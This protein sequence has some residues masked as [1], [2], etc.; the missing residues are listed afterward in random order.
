MR[1]R[2]EGVPP[3]SR[4]GVRNEVVLL[5][6]LHTGRPHRHAVFATTAFGVANAHGVWSLALTLP[7]P[8]TGTAPLHA[9]LVASA[10]ELRGVGRNV[11]TR[12]VAPVTLAP[13]AH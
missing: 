11:L 13:A 10:M 12:R 5:L 6:P 7:S 9:T 8:Q 2:V 3:F 1:E 4:L